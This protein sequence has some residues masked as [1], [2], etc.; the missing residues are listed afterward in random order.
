MPTCYSP[1]RHFTH[2][3]KG[4][5]SFDLHVLSTPPAFV[6]SQDQTLHNNI[7]YIII[8]E[9][10]PFPNRA[11]KERFAR[12]QL[13]KLIGSWPR[14]EWRNQGCD[15]IR[16]P[17]SKP[18]NDYLV[19]KELY[20]QKICPTLV[21]QKQRITEHRPEVKT[22]F[23]LFL[24]RRSLYE[25]IEY[26]LSDLGWQAET[27]PADSPMGKTALLCIGGPI[28][29]L[30]RSPVKRLK[31]KT[32]EKVSTKPLNPISLPPISKPNRPGC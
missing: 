24:V 19:F 13:E 1:V 6:L 14:H 18:S 12:I 3:P 22:F 25:Y 11:F 9:S 2:P 8:S 7:L 28:L 21:G 23:Y 15:M 16:T 29:I 5:F 20:R 10:N 27:C 30:N 4:A 32:S 17:A 26:T 31:P